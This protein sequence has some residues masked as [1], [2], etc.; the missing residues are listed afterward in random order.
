M[1]TPKHFEE[2]RIETLREL[3]AAR[4]LATVVTT[5]A[6][7]I[8]ANP[9]PLLWRDDGSAHGALIGHVARANPMWREH[10]PEAEVLAIFHGPEAYVT[11]AWYPTKAETGK[12]V[13]TWNYVVVQARGRMRVI[14]D[15]AWLRAQVEALTARM[16][17]G[18]VSPW[19]LADA[20]AD[21]IEAM[22]SAIVGIEI[23]IGDLVGKWK[24]S[25]NQPA[26]NQDGVVAGLEAAADDSDAH[27]MARLVAERRDRK[28]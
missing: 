7:G 22:L 10:R 18:R 13:P 25:Q 16:E 27:V 15:R 3:I 2:T 26:R 20:P 14:E 6:R 8:D 11:P 23:A 19:G 24:T 9:I 21:Y 5:T 1:Y 12:A 28:G 17:A 4:P